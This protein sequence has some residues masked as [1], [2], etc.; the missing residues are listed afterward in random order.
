MVNN[1][2]LIKFAS[3]FNDI[4]SL[5]SNGADLEA[6]HYVVPWVENNLMCGKKANGGFFASKAQL[7]R[8]IFDILY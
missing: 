2:E 5:S 1:D 8:L 4:E 7:G 6:V 3:L